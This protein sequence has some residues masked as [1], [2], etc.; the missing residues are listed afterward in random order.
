MTAS[1]DRATAVCILRVERQEGGLVITMTTNYDLDRRLYTA[2]PES[3]RRFADVDT[4]LAAT[5]EFLR[6]FAEGRP[7]RG[8]PAP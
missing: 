6:S 7:R 3:A 1:K 8:D 2:R 5:D 4:A